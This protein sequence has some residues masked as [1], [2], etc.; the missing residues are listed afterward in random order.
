MACQHHEGV[1]CPA[2][3]PVIYS[4]QTPPEDMREQSPMVPTTKDHGIEKGLLFGEKRIHGTTYPS[5]GQPESS[6][7]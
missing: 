7:P 4:S 6:C 2:W 1:L 5:G 3:V